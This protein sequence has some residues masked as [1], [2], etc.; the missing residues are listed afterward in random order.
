VQLFDRNQASPNSKVKLFGLV[1]LL[2]VAITIP[3]TLPHFTHPSM[4]YHIILHIASLAIA[5]FLS[6]IA[7][8]AYTRSG[9]ARLLFMALGFVTLAILEVLMLL[10]ATGNL[11]EQMIPAVNVELPHIVL[12]IMIT[13]FGLGVLKVN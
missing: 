8:I 9:K 1:C 5:I 11:E 10:S 6:F 12:L 7:L 13:L 4:I 2:V 3:I